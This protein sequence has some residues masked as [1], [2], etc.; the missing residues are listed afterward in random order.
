MTRTTA[1]FSVWTRLI[2]IVVVCVGMSLPTVSSAQTV[3]SEQ[4]R[5]AE[6]LVDLS[7]GT[8]LSKAVDA[9]VEQSAGQMEGLT[10]EQRV[11]M[12][13]NMGAMAMHMVEGILEDMTEIY[14]ASFTEA[15]LRAQVTFYE[16]P[17]GRAVANKAFDI[18]VQ[19]GE[20]M[21]DRQVIFL[22]DLMTKYCGAFDC[23]AEGQSGKD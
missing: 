1:G 13:E 19:Q 21:Q 14:A 17:M 7:Q 16:S 4:R 20:V 12:R 23:P 2:A 18:G 10:A 3:S 8:N 9:Q 6:R 15:E 22:R 5:L 11:W